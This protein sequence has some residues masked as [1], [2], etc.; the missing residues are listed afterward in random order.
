VGAAVQAGTGN[1]FVVSGGDH[2]LWVVDF[3]GTDVVAIDPAK[4]RD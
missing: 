3:A 2:L 1:P 4:A